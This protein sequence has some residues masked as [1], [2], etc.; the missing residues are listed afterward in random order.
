MSFAANVKTIGAILCPGKPFVGQTPH[1]CT[2]NYLLKRVD[3]EQ[4][5]GLR[6]EV[7]RGLLRKKCFEGERLQGGYYPVA[8]DGTGCLT[9]QTKHCAHCLTKTKEGVTTYYHPVLEA[10]LVVGGMALSVGTEF[11]EN[12][13]EGASKQDCELK[14]FYRLAEKLKETFPQLRIVLLL[15]GLYAAG[16]VFE[17][18]RKNR[19]AYLITFKEG[20]L[21]A[22]FSEYTTLKSLLQDQCLQRKI[23]DG[24]CVQTYRWVNDIDYQERPLHA[25]ECQEEKEGSNKRFVLISS[26]RVTAA[27]VVELTTQ[28]RSRWGIENQG[29]NVQK[30]GGYGLEHAYSENNTAMKNFYVMMQ[31]AHIINQLMEKGSLLRDYLKNSLGSLKVFSLKLWAALTESRLEESRL[32]DCLGTRIQIRFS[33]P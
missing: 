1:G 7:V 22:T 10:K 3:P 16:P 21:P 33:S 12:V 11:I 20:S 29:F 13:A 23:N 6:T 15:D 2:L 32:R 26:V 8:V 19:W 24:G 27:N 9:F 31:I 4:M 17:V 5:A 18:C 30:N 28:G 14:A 25:L